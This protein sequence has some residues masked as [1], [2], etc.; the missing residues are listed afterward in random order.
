[1]EKFGQKQH[2]DNAMKGHR[3]D[4]GKVLCILENQQKNAVKL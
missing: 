1:M 3:S 4:F 2:R